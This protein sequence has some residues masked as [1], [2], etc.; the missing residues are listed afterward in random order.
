MSEMNSPGHK[1]LLFLLWC[2]I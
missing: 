2:K 1:G